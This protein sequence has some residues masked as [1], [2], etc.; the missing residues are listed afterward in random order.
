MEK[1]IL[2]GAGGHAKTIVDT[3]EHLGK[4][5]ISGFMMPGD[6]GGELYRGYRVIGYDEEM[7]R[8]YASGIH[9]A[10]IAIGFMGK[11]V[12]RNKMYEKLKTAGFYLPA[13]IDPSAVVAKDAKIGEGA[14]IGRRVV[15][16]ADAYVGKAC[17]INT[18]AIIEHECM[19]GDF[20]H[21]AVASVLCGQ[22]TIGENTFVGA[23]ATV[24]QG[25][26]IGNNCIVG[27][28]SVV[29][30]D[31]NMSSISMGVPARITKIIE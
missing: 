27:A 15:I 31:I 9:N 20:S 10:V 23:N 26:K 22:V 30:K 25:C 3:I 14:Y 5:E 8:I 11:S 6:V 18:G 7:D 2:V 17:I 19:V 28:G 13:I 4:Y 16:N 1:I 24:L 21:V 12:L 29:T